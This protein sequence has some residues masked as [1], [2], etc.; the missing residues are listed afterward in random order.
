MARGGAQGRVPI[1]VVYGV[2]RNR[3]AMK[4]WDDAEKKLKN[5]DV[6]G[7]R[8]N[9]D[10]AL[11]SDPTLWPALY[12]RAKIFIFQHEYELAVRDCSEALRRYPPIYRSRIVARNC[13]RT[14]GPVRRSFKGNQSLHFDSSSQRR[15]WPRS[16]R[17]CLASRDLSRSSL[18]QRI[19]GDQRR[20]QRMQTAAVAGRIRD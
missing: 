15:P 13:Q 10:A 12:T 18:S 20:N 7:A 6:N 16:E 14:P 17:P 8:R 3:T 1:T 11:R 9:V 4:F 2:G 5:G 19:T